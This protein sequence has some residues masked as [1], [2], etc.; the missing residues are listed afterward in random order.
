MNTLH[1]PRV[2]HR[3]GLAFGAAALILPVLYLNAAAGG[4]GDIVQQQPADLPAA[5]TLSA[6]LL[7]TSE[8]RLGS[9]RGHHEACLV[10]LQTAAAKLYMVQ[11]IVAPEPEGTVVP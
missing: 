3:R 1:V 6:Q 5:A 7:G 8:A 10:A 4:D 2:R 9:C 11:T